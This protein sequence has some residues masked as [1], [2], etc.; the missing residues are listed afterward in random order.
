MCSAQGRLSP[1]IITWFDLNPFLL[2]SLYS[3]LVLKGAFQSSQSLISLHFYLFCKQLSQQQA[4]RPEML[5]VP[6]WECRWWRYL[7][8]FDWKL[9]FFNESKTVAWKRIVLSTNTL[10]QEQSPV[11]RRPWVLLIEKCT[12]VCLHISEQMTINEYFLFAIGDSHQFARNSEITF[13]LEK[14]RGA[15]KRILLFTLN[16]YLHKILKKV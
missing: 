11:P 16:W 6:A 13:L 3:G 1:I 5:S 8:I 14:K 4:W 7:L 15:R 2:T 10:I 9:Q 12:T